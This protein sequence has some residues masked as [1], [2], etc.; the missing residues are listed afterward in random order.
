MKIGRWAAKDLMMIEDEDYFVKKAKKDVLF[1]GI[2]F[3]EVSITKKKSQKY[4]D[5]P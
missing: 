4:S 3:R 5:V 2:W 1:L